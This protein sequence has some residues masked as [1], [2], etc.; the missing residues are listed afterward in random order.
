M[1]GNGR[2][3][4]KQG[5]SKSRGP[6]DN[7]RHGVRT[8][9]ARFL[10]A[11]FAVLVTSLASD[12]ILALVGLSPEPRIQI[13]HPPDY[14]ETVKMLE[15]EY[16]FE[17][18]GQGLRY[19]DIPLEKPEDEYRVF[20][21]GDSYTEGV[22]VEAEKRF[23]ELLE[24]DFS[25]GGRVVRFINGGISGT[26]PLEYCRLF[27]HVGLNYDPDA[28]LICVYANDISNTFYRCQ[29]G[30]LYEV[31]M[32][33][34]GLGRFVYLLW[35]RTYMFF[36]HYL[37]FRKKEAQRRPDDF[38]ELV[39]ARARTLNISEEEYEAWKAR[40]PGD[41]AEAVNRGELTPVA[42]ATGLI[43]S[44][45]W[46]NSID[47]ESDLA[48]RKFKAMTYILE[49]A[50]HV[51][52]E[53]G[54][55]VGVIYIPSPFQYNPAFHDPDVLNPWRV[56]GVA[57]NKKWLSEETGIQKL[58]AEWA[59]GA[60]IHYLDLTPDLRREAYRH[61][62]NFPMDGHWNQLGHEAAKEAI[63]RWIRK[64]NVFPMIEK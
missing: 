21:A 51:C 36:R 57:T 15:F 4:K 6:G 37:E 55:P 43:N 25:K 30:M 35:P 17:T 19:K 64:D 42:L 40:I 13:A 47:V 50:I 53:R 12:R 5:T 10:L 2:M 44:Q 28:L 60:G 52:R 59:E 63:A 14:K 26:G 3:E 23:T 46:N 61:V 31:E 38:F 9:L 11:L 1:P 16:A 7:K 29:A 22:G 41:L 33:I 20:V 8:Y 49:E 54:L 24:K 56:A 18:N 62:L 45:Y 58:M 34:S 48:Y 27:L 32:E 39:H